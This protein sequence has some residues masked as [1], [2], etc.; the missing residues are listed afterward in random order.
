MKTILA[1]LPVAKSIFA[2]VSLAIDTFFVHR[3][4]LTMHQRALFLY[5]EKQLRGAIDL[6]DVSFS[7]KDFLRKHRLFLER[8]ALEDL[9]W[10]F[11]SSSKARAR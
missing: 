6:V 10:F 5:Y 4:P 2:H 7:K 3:K 9:F 8:P 1:N 11:I